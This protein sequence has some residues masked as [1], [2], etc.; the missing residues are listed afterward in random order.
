[1]SWASYLSRPTPL[2]LVA[3]LGA[4]VTV[5]A[6]AA[7]NGVPRGSRW[8]PS[9]VRIGEQVHSVYVGS[10]KAG[11]LIDASDLPWFDNN[12]DGVLNASD[13]AYRRSLGVRHVDASGVSTRRAPP[14]LHITANGAER[15]TLFA[16]RH[17][18][19]VALRDINLVQGARTSGR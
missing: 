3:A 9:T 19:L 6:D 15:R 8:K 13:H 5:Q 2:L 10:W 18:R 4:F 7:P 16:V 12:D 11:D 17:V 14:K 1:M